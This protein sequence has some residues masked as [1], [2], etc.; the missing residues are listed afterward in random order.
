MLQVAQ[1]LEIVT[2]LEALIHQLGNNFTTTKSIVLRPF[3]QLRA[4]HVV[5]GRACGAAL[6]TP[7]ILRKATAYDIAIMLRL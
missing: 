2:T 7:N 5:F 3:E 6:T 4:R 1:S